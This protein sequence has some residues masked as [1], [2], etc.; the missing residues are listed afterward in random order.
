MSRTTTT[1]PFSWR[2]RILRRHRWVIRRTEERSRDAACARCGRERD[3]RYEHTGGIGMAG[4]LGTGGG[5]AF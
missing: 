1:R 2:C 3:D 5:G 4:M